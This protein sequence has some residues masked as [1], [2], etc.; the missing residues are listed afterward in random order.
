MRICT[1]DQADSVCGA[2]RPQGC[3]LRGVGIFSTGAAG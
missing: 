2:M 1:D 3:L